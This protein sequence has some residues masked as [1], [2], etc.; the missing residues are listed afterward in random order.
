MTSLMWGHCSVNDWH[1]RPTSRTLWITITSTWNQLLD[2]ASDYADVGKTMQRETSHTMRGIGYWRNAQETT[3]SEKKIFTGLVGKKCPVKFFSS[4]RKF[5][6]CWANVA[7]SWLVLSRLCWT[8]PNALRRLLGQVRNISTEWE[9]LLS[10]NGDINKWKRGFGWQ[11][12]HI[13]I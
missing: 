2:G 8:L 3:G 4:S 12:I 5:F 9:L 6:R 1:N 10:P 13:L 11:I 7:L